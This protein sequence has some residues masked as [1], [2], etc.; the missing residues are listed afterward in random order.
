MIFGK[1]LSIFGQI[2]FISDIFRS[3][4]ACLGNKLVI[5]AQFLV[6]FGLKDW[7]FRIQ[8][9]SLTLPTNISPLAASIVSPR[10][11]NKFKTASTTICRLSLLLKSPNYSSKVQMAIMSLV[12][13]KGR[14]L[15]RSKLDFC[16]CLASLNLEGNKDFRGSCSDAQL[17]LESGSSNPSCGH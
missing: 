13:L 14:R 6:I 17:F 7:I 8:R 9:E 10:A 3:I 15:I 4:L 5:L 16:L 1:F 11:Y 2:L 12:E